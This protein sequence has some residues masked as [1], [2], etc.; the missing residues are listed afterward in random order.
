[1]RALWHE[2]RDQWHPGHWFLRITVARLMRMTEN[3]DP[4]RTAFVLVDP[5]NDFFAEDGKFY[6]RLKEVAESVDLHQHL[7]ELLAAI[8]AAG[9]QVVIAPH[10][11]WRPGDFEGWLRPGRPHRGIRDGKV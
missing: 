9:I 10:R 2:S 11:R 3:Y 7:R 5:Y 1:M 6:P 8:R 4:A